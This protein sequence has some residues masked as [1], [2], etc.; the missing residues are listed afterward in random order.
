M[1][2]TGPNNVGFQMWNMSKRLSAVSSGAQLAAQELKRH[3]AAKDLNPEDFAEIEQIADEYEKCAASADQ[4][5]TRLVEVT[6]QSD[7]TLVDE[8]DIVAV[9][10]NHGS[11]SAL[12]S[13]VQAV[14]QK[15]TS[16]TESRILSVRLNGFLARFPEEPH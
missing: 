4:T 8:S 13:Q 10:G 7:P 9:I 16:V 2:L 3:R 11:D 6:K 1:P 15:D 12:M 5:W 14:W